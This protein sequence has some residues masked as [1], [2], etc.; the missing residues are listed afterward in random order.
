MAGVPDTE[1]DA[2]SRGA[3]TTRVGAAVTITTTPA[4]TDEAVSI[5]TGSSDREQVLMARRRDFPDVIGA[6]RK[7]PA[8]VQAIFR[9]PD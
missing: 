5:T 9:N 7:T 1:L 4:A 3:A 2:T 6:R 8:T